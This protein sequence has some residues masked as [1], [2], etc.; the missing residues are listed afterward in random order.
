MFLSQGRVIIE[1]AF[2][3][4]KC[5]FTVIRDVQNVDLVIMVKFIIADFTLRNLCMDEDF[6]CEE[7]PDGC[8]RY[9]DND[10]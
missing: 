6:I 3:R 4:L 9:D 10:M 2:G 1:K 5:R 8:P 7:H